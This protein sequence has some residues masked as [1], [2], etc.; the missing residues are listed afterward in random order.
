MDQV[1]SIEAALAVADEVSPT[2][3]RAVTALKVLR[4]ALAHAG[5]GTALMAML[6]ERMRQVSV[7]GWTPEHDDEHPPGELECAAAC[8]AMWS[9]TSPESEEA[10]SELPRMIRWWW[11]W[12]Q[13]WF[14]PT[15]RKRNLEKAGAL[16]LAAYERELRAEA[17]NG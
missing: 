1:M 4:V 3:A 13:S 11:P 14:K 6:E 12:E 9:R 7:E 16:L 5:P 17:R 8:Y 10:G 15:S 2:P